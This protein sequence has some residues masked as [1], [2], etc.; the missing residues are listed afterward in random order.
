MITITESGVTF[1]PFAQDTIFRVENSPCAAR[2]G[3]IKACEFV[4]WSASNNKL[5]FIEARASV[6]NPQKSLSEYEQYF[7]DMLEK[8]D[9]SLQLLLAGTAPRHTELVR[10]LGPS[11]AN[12]NWQQ[13]DI[14]F[15]LVIPRAPREFLNSLTDKL[16]QTLHRQLKIWRINI[17]VINEDMARSHGLLSKTA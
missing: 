8:F 9:N 1:G 5:V 17:F 10:E 14:Q 16:R 3:G 11:M 6:P 7:S 2:L 15:Y 13:A 12:I 4:W